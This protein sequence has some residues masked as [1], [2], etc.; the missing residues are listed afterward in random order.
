MKK[1]TQFIVFALLLVSKLAFSAESD[2][3]NKNSGFDFNPI[4]IDS[5]DGIGATVGIEYKFNGELLSKDFDSKDSGASFNPNI[6]IGSAVVSYSGSGTVAVSKVRNPKNFLEF[7]LDAKL[8]YSAPRAGS[9]TGGLFSKYETDQSFSNKQLVYGLGATYGKYAA[10]AANDFVALDANY[11]RVDPK[12]DSERKTAIGTTTLD[13][14]YRWN[15]EFLYM[16]PLNWKTVRTVEFN[17]RYFLEN[18]APSAIKSAG[19]DK[20]ELATLRVGLKNDLFIAYSTGK[21]PFDRKNDNIFQ[22]GFSYKL[23]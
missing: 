9:V 13:S 18:N 1:P 23:N 17:Y 22:I 5:K 10:L 6:A 15:L 16:Y 8:R 19:L 7:L 14:Y 11:G 2:A 21:L 3:E 20:H 12:D 4:V